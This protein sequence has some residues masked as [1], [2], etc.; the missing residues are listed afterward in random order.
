VK[1]P[2]RGE[3]RERVLREK[4]RDLQ[5]ELRR[6]DFDYFVLADQVVDAQC[7]LQEGQPIDDEVLD[8]FRHFERRTP[9]D[10][11]LFREAGR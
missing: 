8:A 6:L 3:A 2:T 11:S 9:P 7:R 10:P 5:K 1:K 4:V